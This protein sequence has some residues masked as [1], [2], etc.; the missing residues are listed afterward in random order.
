MTEIAEALGLGLDSFVYLD[1]SPVERDAVKKFLPE[2][3]VP[4]FP[5]RPEK[6]LNW[7]MREVAPLYFGKYAIT[8]EDASKTE[9]YRANEARKK[10]A[11][12]FDLD[13]YLAELGIECAIHID[14]ANRLVRAAQM[15]QK[16]NQFNLTT[17]RYE[18][19]DLARFVESPEHAVLMLDYRDRYGDEGSVGLAIVDLAE[20]RIDTFLQSCRVIGRKVEERLLDKAI[21]LCRSRGHRRI[22]GEYI[23]TRKNQIVAD[24][25]ETQGFAPVLKEADGRTVFEKNLDDGR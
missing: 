5:D 25:Y 14:A 2:I 16:T 23:P 1:D 19:T 18:V 22:V 11:A 7:F 21:D 15:T 3:A 10:L 20:G 12:S 4:D 13:G 24:F 6:L 17:R 9:Q 8:V